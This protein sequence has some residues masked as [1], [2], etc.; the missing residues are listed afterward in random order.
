MVIKLVLSFPGLPSSHRER[1][2]GRGG[3]G[4]LLYFHCITCI[5]L[6][7]SSLLMLHVF[8]ASSSLRHGMVCDL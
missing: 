4:C 6:M 7:C 8:I 5:A 1:E 3:G 2:K